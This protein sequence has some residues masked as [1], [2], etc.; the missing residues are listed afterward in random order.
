MRNIKPIKYKIY[1]NKRMPNKMS[2][3]V[4]CTIY[5]ICID[6]GYFKIIGPHFRYVGFIVAPTLWL[7]L[8]SWITFFLFAG[9]TYKSY[10]NKNRLSDNHNDGIWTISFWVYNMLYDLLACNIFNTS[11]VCSGQSEFF[12]K[13]K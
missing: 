7:M 10:Q 8:Y 13:K 9:M 11:F 3:F 1:F 6:I 12:A 2:F 5:R 4:W